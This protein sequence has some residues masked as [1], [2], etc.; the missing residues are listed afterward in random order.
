M[1]GTTGH[2]DKFLIEI[3]EFRVEEQCLAA[4]RAAELL[5]AA[6]GNLDAQRPGPPDPGNLTAYVRAVRRSQSDIWQATQM[7]VVA[8]GNLSKL[9]WG[10]SGKFAIEREPLRRA[11]QVQDTSL[12]RPTTMRNHFE[13][14]DDRIDRWWKNSPGRNYIDASIGPVS[15]TGNVD[16]TDF[17]RGYDPAT[18]DLSFWGTNL[19]VRKV[20]AEVETILEHAA[21]ELDRTM[22]PP[23]PPSAP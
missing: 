22:L 3:F 15:V 23:E 21:D 17:F 8:A 16:R 11:L 20:C 5:N 19:N 18:G 1:G 14:F 9:F 13:H 10:E 2:M 12:L 4:L 6:V 7:L